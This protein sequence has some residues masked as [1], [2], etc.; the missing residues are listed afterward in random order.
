VVVQPSS[1]AG[2]LISELEARRVTVERVSVEDYRAACGQFFDSVT[3]SI[4][5]TR[6]SSRCR[7]LSPEVQRA[8]SGAQ[9]TGSV[10]RVVN[11]P[12]LVVNSSRNG[13]TSTVSG[14]RRISRP[15]TSCG[16]SGRR[17]TSTKPRR[18]PHDALVHGRSYV[19]VWA[20]PEDPKTPKITVE[21]AEQM[22]VEFEPGTTNVASAAKCWAEDDMAYAT[23]YLPDTIDFYE[24]RCPD[25]GP[26]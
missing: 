4:S 11:W 1:P 21:S 3:D 6:A 5:T 7:F 24:L 26:M 19:I 22:T 14:W 9:Q 25:V 23:L 17:T 12:R 2:S 13:S 18:W 8:V 15:T 20:D 10:A 16:G